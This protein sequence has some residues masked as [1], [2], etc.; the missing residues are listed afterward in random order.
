MPDYTEKDLQMYMN[1]A[2]EYA[3]RATLPTEG[4]SEFYENGDVYERF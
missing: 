3:S 1:Q 4:N 2:M